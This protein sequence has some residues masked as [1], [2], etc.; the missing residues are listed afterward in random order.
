[1]SHDEVVLCPV[2]EVFLLGEAASRSQLNFVA[3]EVDAELARRHRLHT[4]PKEP[5]PSLEGRLQDA[6]PVPGPVEV[7]PGQGWAYLKSRGTAEFSRAAGPP[8]EEERGDAPDGSPQHALKC[9]WCGR[10]GRAVNRVARGQGQLLF[11][12]PVLCQVCRVLAGRAERSEH[13]QRAAE[14]LREDLLLERPA[15]F[16]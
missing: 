3:K 4:E 14:R 10:P 5:A 1:M 16:R 11:R 12:S 6:H 8:P 2:C 9:G 7:E 13:R 15:E